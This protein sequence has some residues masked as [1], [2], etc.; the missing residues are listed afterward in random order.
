MAQRWVDSR[1][2]RLC[3]SLNQR[4][5]FMDA[6]DAATV[7][8][9][10]VDSISAAL[11]ISK[12]AARRYM[13]T[14]TLDGLADAMTE[15][16]AEEQPGVDLMAQPRDEAVPAKM[17]GRTASGLA[18]AVLLYLQLDDADSSRDHVRALAQHL[19]LLGQMM[20]ESTGPTT[21][22]PKAFV[23]RMA[24][25]LDQAANL[26]QAS[27]DLAAAFRRDAMRLRGL[28]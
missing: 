7:V 19:S 4:G 6:D 1:A 16:L 10:R 27:T 25:Q 15:I 17:V 12:T 3:R 20:Y 21:H 9:E 14:E 13:T 18:E 11:R 28:R 26:P 8:N 24:A 5:L 23:A 2:E 22:V